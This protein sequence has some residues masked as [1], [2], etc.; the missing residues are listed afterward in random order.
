MRIDGSSLTLLR[1]RLDAPARAGRRSVCEREY[2]LLAVRERGG[3]IGFGEASPLPGYSRETVA[4][5]ARALD[6][7]HRRLSATSGERLPRLPQL[8]AAACFALETALLDLAGQLWGTSAAQCLRGA[9]PLSEVPLNGLVTGA[10]A[11][12]R[13]TS[14]LKLEKRGFKAVKLKLDPDASWERQLRELETLRRRLGAGVALRL[15]ANG[16]WPVP[17]ARRRLEELQALDLELVEEPVHGRA[18][19]RLG[20][21]A[22]PWAAD[23]S[24]SIPGLGGP[25]VRA[26]GCAAVV[27]KP[28]MLGLG[29][30]RKL[31]EQAARCGRG[32]IVT[33]LF[34]GPVALAAT[35][36]LALSLRDPPLACG[37]D[38][39]PGARAWG[40]GLAT[41]PSAVLR[42][43]PAPGLGFSERERRILARLAEGQWTA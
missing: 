34:D 32:V 27:I 29:A 14:A 5:C 15:D 41:K 17:T 31:A 22:T 4:A 13:L 35:R 3:A 36:Q 26:K 33:H 20:Q 38:S 10:T 8:P 21:T 30:S 23:E 18:L 40:R 39:H 12:I 43:C 25:L 37:L 16:A 28:A 11:S 1:R 6:G 7:A 2:L 19:L 42:P 24:L 9:A